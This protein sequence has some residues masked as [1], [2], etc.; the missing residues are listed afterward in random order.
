MGVGDYLLSKFNLY[1]E[2]IT[3]LETMK[4]NIRNLPAMILA[5]VT[6]LTVSCHKNEEFVVIPESVALVGNSDLVFGKGTTEVIEFKVTPAEAVFDYDISSPEC[7]VKLELRNGYGTS[8]P[9]SVKL[10]SISLLSESEGLYKAVIRD[11]AASDSYND[12]VRLRITVKGND[13]KFVSIYSDTFNVRIEKA[14][15]FRTI[16]FLKESNETAL[17][18]DFTVDISSG[19]ASLESPLIGSPLLAASF[20]A[21]DAKVYVNGVEQISGVTVNDYSSPVTFTVRSKIE[22]TFTVSLLYSTLPKVFI[23]TPGGKE[24]PSKWE[25]WLSGSTVTVYNPDWTVNYSGQTGIRGRG[26]STWSYP[27]K[28]YA[29]KLDS[30]AEIL[31]MPKHKRWVLLANWMDRTLLRN[32]VSFNLAE[33]TDLAYTP[34]GQFVE[35]FINGKHK[36]NYFLC[37]HIKVDENRVDI[38]E[39]DEDETDGG[40]IMELDSYYDEMYKFKSEKRGLP[41]MFKDP[42][43]VTTEQF[44]FMQGFVNNLEASLYDDARFARGEYKDYLDVDSFI[45][46]WLVMELTGIWEPNHPKSCYMHKD[47][48]GK[49]TAGPVW[50][51]DWET[52]MPTTWWR[53]KDTLYYDRLFQ[54]ESFK[55]R[56]K[57]R[58]NMFRDDFATLPEFI[59]SEAAKIAV[60]E[61]FNHKM[62]PINQVVNQDENLPFEEA[63]NRMISSYEAKLKWMEKEIGKW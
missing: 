16:S 31:G 4:L 62:W 2:I 21:G 32:C 24:I 38:D 9:T 53:I 42:D 18:Q 30:K 28:P 15:L 10:E 11:N 33:R 20:D 39:L 52:Y 1:L 40:Y 8:T 25:D 54:D 49:L 37:E 46:W 50:D 55:A 41:Y 51:F 14:P 3:T 7:Q 43:E 36:G 57:E 12:K 13:E 34:R 5:A 29:L 35:V 45:D 61:I 6:A 58:W 27:K 60:S 26:N 48:G 59:R 22:Y 56:V 47:K 44:E 17:N 63:V 19:S 23:E